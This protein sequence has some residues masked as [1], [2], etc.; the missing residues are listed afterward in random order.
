MPPSRKTLPN[1][2]NRLTSTRKTRENNGRLSVRK[3]KGKPKEEEV[4][5]AIGLLE[6]K[7]KRL[8]PARGKRIAL[9]V[10]NNAPYTEILSKAVKKWKAYHSD[11]YIEDEEYLLVFESGKQAQ[12]IPGTVEFFTLSRYQEEIGK[13][14]KRIVLYLCSQMDVNAAEHGQLN[15]CAMKSIHYCF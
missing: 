9:R 2:L 14:Y 4:T 10:S 12:F 7:E 15:L 8:K 3:K 5:I 1:L 13:D 6:W 11:L